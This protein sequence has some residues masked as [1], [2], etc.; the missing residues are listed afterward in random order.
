MSTIIAKHV[1]TPDSTAL[2]ISSNFAVGNGSSMVSR[3]AK[4]DTWDLRVDGTLTDD[5]LKPYMSKMVHLMADQ[6]SSMNDNSIQAL[7]RFVKG[8]G[9]LFSGALR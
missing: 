4:S 8:G 2:V 5:G 7:I 9:Q 3:G 1:V 6:N